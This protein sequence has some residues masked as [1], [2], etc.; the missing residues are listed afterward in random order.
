MVLTESQTS[1]QEQYVGNLLRLCGDDLDPPLILAV[2]L[3]DVRFRLQQNIKKFESGQ[4]IEHRW[5][6]ADPLFQYFWKV[7]DERHRCEQLTQML[8]L[9]RERQFLLEVKK[10]HT[11]Y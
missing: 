7:L 8:D 10:R 2:C 5:Q 3:T 6:K 11:G 1:W 4:N 9:A